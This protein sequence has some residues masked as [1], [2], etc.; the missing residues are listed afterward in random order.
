[1]TYCAARPRPCRHFPEREQRP[2]C[3]AALIDAVHSR[4]NRQPCIT[5]GRRV[6]ALRRGKFGVAASAPHAQRRC[7]RLYLRRQFSN[8]QLLGLEFT[9][10]GQYARPLL[11]YLALLALHVVISIRIQQLILHR[12][13]LSIR[14][15]GHHVRLNLVHFHSYHAVSDWLRTILKSLHKSHS[16]APSR[17]RRPKAEFQRLAG[18]SH[19]EQL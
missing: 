15:T 5:R 3:R 13:D 9:L 12:L 14:R 8:L 1:M 17:D 2:R 6:H 11:S 10:L 7:N 18:V 16:C 4:G 19:I